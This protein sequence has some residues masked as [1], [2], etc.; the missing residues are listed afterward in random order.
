MKKILLFLLLFFTPSL[1]R[2]QATNSNPLGGNLTVQDAGTCSTTGSFLWQ[3]LPSNAS[4]TTVN[5]S[6]T[7][8]GTVTIRMSNN[9]GGSWATQGTQTSAGTVSYPSNGFTDVCADVTTYTS[10][11]FGVTI[12]TGLNTGPVGPQ[13][14]PGTGSGSGI[15]PVTTVPATCTPGG[16]NAQVNLTVANGGFQPGLLNCIATNVFSADTS[17]FTKYYGLPP[18]SFGAKGDTHVYFDC[19][20]TSNNHVTC[21]SS[22]FQSTDVGKWFESCAVGGSCATGS[23]VNQGTITFFNSAT[24]VTV[25]LTSGTTYTNTKMA[26][27]TDDDAA[28]QSWGAAMTSTPTFGV[29]PQV[30]GG[31]LPQGGYAIK[32]PLKII[33][34]TSC[35]PL[36]NAATCGE[37]A[38]LQGVGA[39]LAPGLWLSGASTTASFIYVR[40]G[41][42]FTWPTTADDIGALTIGNWAFGSI[43]NF[44]VIGDNQAH[45]TTGVTGNIG[46]MVFSGYVGGAPSFDTH[47]WVNSVWV[48]GFHNT[49]NN[50]C[51][52]VTSKMDFESSYMYSAIES[53]DFNGCF[54]NSQSGQTGATVLE[55]IHLDTIFFE[56]P[57]SHNI[58]IGTTNAGVNITLK[59]LSITNCHAFNGTHALR[60]ISAVTAAQE[61]VELFNFRSTT[62]SSG[63]TFGIQSGTGTGMNL[64]CHGCYLEDTGSGGS[65]VAATTGSAGD[66]F[67]F[68][69]GSIN[70]QTGTNAFNN[71]GT[72]F[73]YGT[74]LTGPTVANIQT[75]S[76]NTYSFVPIS[77]AN[78]GWGGKGTIQGTLNISN[79]G[80][81]Q[82]SGN[83]ALS[84]N[85]GTSPT[86]TA[87]AGFAQNHRFTITAQATTGANP[88]I[89]D[90]LPSPLPASTTICTARMEG[91]TGTTTSITQTTQSATAPVFTFNGTPGAGSTYVV[92]VQCGP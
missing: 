48:Q 51:G 60:F 91:G 13:G 50:M 29:P 63:P 25:S 11:N 3:H 36:A 30:R 82:T 37:G 5:L 34:P 14:P 49:T 80:P 19:G 32:Q 2:A 67:N 86:I 81:A 27:G 18:Q 61:T 72:I 43:Q 47:I 66:Q 70:I 92:D 15:T 26:F 56:N 22:H 69:G 55:K 28:M 40:T 53:N 45:T 58:I 31:Y 85:W 23:T 16:T 57:G 73:V 9:G 62:G 7:F 20:M 89:T 46:G 17:Y 84:A 59:Q 74:K 52:L 65:N 83:I 79:Q 90:T 88:T 38:P 42:V 41:A 33:Y 6:G 44:A 87:V 68:Y 39:T 71:T 64:D 10:G 78:G 4:S 35:A 54:G 1:L 77:G 76:G 75:G 24:D 8:S 12:T 21:A